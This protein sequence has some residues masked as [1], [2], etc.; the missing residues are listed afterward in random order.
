MEF[1]TRGGNQTID[2]PMPYAVKYALR[3]DEEVVKSIGELVDNAVKEAE[4]PQKVIP[5]SRPTPHFILKL[6]KKIE[7]GK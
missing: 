7:Y 5:I 3:K 4:L 6:V 2:P 1:N